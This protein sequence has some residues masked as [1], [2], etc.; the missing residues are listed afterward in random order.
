MKNVFEFWDRAREIYARARS[1]FDQ[2]EKRKLMAE[3]DGYP[4]QAE[5]IRRAQAITKAE[6]PKPQIFPDRPPA[7]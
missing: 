5:E 6:Y 3:A 2:A 4:R 7:F 1:T